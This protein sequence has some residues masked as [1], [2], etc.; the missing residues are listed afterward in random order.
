M[1]QPCHNRPMH[2]RAFLVMIG[3]VLTALLATSCAPTATTERPPEPTDLLHALEIPE[4]DSIDWRRTISGVEVLGSGTSP[5]A[6]ELQLLERALGEIPEGLKATGAPRR[7]YRVRDGVTTAAEAAY[8]IG[9]DI[10]LVDRTFADIGAA[11][12]TLDLTKILA[13]EMTHVAQFNALDEDDVARALD[14]DLPDPIPISSFVAE[15]ADAVGWTDRGRATGIPDWVL[16]DRNGTTT[17]GGTAPE[18]DMAETV[19]HLTAG[20]AAGFSRKRASWVEDWLN[21]DIDVLAD[22]KPWAPPGSERLR[23]AE[24]LFDEEEV[25]RRATG[26]V[27]IMTYGLPQSSPQLAQLAPV[28]E[29]ELGLRRMAGDLAP[30]SDDRI[31]RWAGFFLRGDGVGFWVELWD[32]RNAPGY[33]DPPDHPVLTYVVLWR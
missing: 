7:I 16:P 15:F 8:A 31:E 29:R 33:V 27:E 17:Y 23:S 4:P 2:R 18:E 5:N 30:G 22:G 9:P 25:E 24:P 1:E 12:V 13:H 6:A 26:P 32:F 28:V 3:A 11:F 21:T 20:E 14:N 10:Y 19:A